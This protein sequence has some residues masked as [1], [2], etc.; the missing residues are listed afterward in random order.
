MSHVHVSLGRRQFVLGAAALAAGAAS[1]DGLGAPSATRVARR[2]SPALTRPLGE[3][4]VVA[5]RDAHGPF[6]LTRVAVFPQATDGDWQRAEAL[7]PGAF[8]PELEWRLDFTC[9][10]IRRHGGRITL[11]DAGIG[12]A[13]SPATWAPLPGRLPTVLTENGIDVDDV[14]TVVLTHVHE[15]H[16][17]WTVTDRG[18]PMF[19]HARYV[20]QRAEITAL[21]D[22]AVLDYA[23]RPLQE[24][25]QLHEVDGAVRLSGGRSGRISVVPTP[26]HTAG[27]QSVLV[28]GSERDVVITG[29][30]LVHAVQLANPE[31][32]YRFETSQETARQTRRSVLADARE[33]RALLA[34]NHLTTPFVDMAEAPTHGAP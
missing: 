19:P 8:G 10:A 31:V 17:G 12:P 28:E 34:T 13:G 24:A 29:D 27:H 30:V 23:V 6:P 16:V 32:G 7:D 18:T 4:E 20:V 11:V 22:G 3:L 21:A 2:Q 1:P 25:G 5:L 33:R 15:D 26:G 14:D 9:F